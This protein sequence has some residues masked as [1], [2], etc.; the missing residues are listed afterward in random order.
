MG[1]DDELTIVVDPHLVPCDLRS[2]RI[3]FQSALDL[4]GLQFT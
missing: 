1:T 4:L 3:A 2:P